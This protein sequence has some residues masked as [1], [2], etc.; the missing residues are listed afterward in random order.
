LPL[1][2]LLRIAWVA[3]V[4]LVIVGS[5]M[6]GDSTPIQALDRL[7]ISDKL[8]HFASYA[9]LGFLPA[10]HEGRRTVMILALGLVALG[11]LLE[12]G[13]LLSPSRD[14]EIL[15]MVAD[16]AGIC[17]G[18]V[19]GWPFRKRAARRYRTEP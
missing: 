18:V 14:F 1:R 4:V 11:V 16:T 13:Q 17:I 15:D 19:A 5:L 12:Y 2:T 9:V 3:G 8:Q 10:L 7:N 6:P